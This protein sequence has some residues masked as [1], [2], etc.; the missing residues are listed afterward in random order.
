LFVVCLCFSFLFPLF[1]D[2]L[3]FEG[4]VRRVPLEVKEKPG[5]VH[6]LGTSLADC[7]VLLPFSFSKLHLSLTLS[8]A[9]YWQKVAALPVFVWVLDQQNGGTPCFLTA[10]ATRWP[11]MC[12]C[13]CVCV[14]VLCS[15][16]C[17]CV[18]VFEYLFIP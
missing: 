5:S 2:Q 16:V 1:K 13:V 4:C 17:V 15:C 9:L 12:V 11:V 8:E 10:K 6:L 18:C 3:P 14:Y 7:P